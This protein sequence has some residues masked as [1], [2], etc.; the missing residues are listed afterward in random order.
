ME[1]SKNTNTVFFYKNSKECDFIVAKDQDISMVVQSAYSV[2]DY[3]T[4]KR[5]V[6]DLIAVCKRLSVQTGRIIT[7]SE[8]DNFTEQNIDIQVIPAYKFLLQF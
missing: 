2:A 4:R 6:E 5:E 1:L 3:K 7:F 8:E